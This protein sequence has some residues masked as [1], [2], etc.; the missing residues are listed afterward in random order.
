MQ[1]YRH[2]IQATHITEPPEPLRVFK[3]GFFSL[4]SSS[5]SGALG[6]L[7]VESST[8]YIEPISS[9]R[10]PTLNATLTDPTLFRTTHTLAEYNHEIQDADNS[11]Q[12][13]TG[14]TMA[15]EGAPIQILTPQNDKLRR[16]LAAGTKSVV[17]VSMRGLVNCNDLIPFRFVVASKI[18]SL[19]YRV[20][21][22]DAH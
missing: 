1:E 6:S 20:P 12:R 3:S 19:A 5:S 7:N 15:L 2:I 16:I 13:S 9:H 17:S 4:P 11:S 18:W 21:G 8:S 22:I 10:E 14:Y